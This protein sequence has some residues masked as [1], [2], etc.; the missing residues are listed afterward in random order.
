[1]CISY[2]LKGFSAPKFVG[3][4]FVLSEVLVYVLVLFIVLVLVSFLILILVL[5]LIFVLA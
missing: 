1:M 2:L 5:A 3:F 4:G